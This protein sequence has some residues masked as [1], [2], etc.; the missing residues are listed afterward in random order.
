MTYTSL[1]ASTDPQYHQGSELVKACRLV[2]NLLIKYL[3]R[4]HY[5][6]FRCYL[7]TT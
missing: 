6:I 2:F 4:N 5:T 7:R 3:V 1:G